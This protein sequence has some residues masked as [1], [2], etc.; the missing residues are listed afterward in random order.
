MSGSVGKRC[1]TYFTMWISEVLGGVFKQV[2]GIIKFWYDN[3]ILCSL[4][5]NGGVGL[6]GVFGSVICICLSL[7]LTS[8]FLMEELHSSMLSLAVM[9]IF[10]FFFRCAGL[11]SVSLQCLLYIYIK[12]SIFSFFGCHQKIVLQIHVFVVVW[13]FIFLVRAALLSLNLMSFMLLT[14]WYPLV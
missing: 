5:L 1:R 7:A 9:G 11:F 4:C 6:E 3:I 13:V 10:L 12:D 8:F 2:E 14:A